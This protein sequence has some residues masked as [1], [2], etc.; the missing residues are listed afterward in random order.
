M[1]PS[2]VVSYQNTLNTSNAPLL[3]SGPDRVSD[4][5]FTNYFWFGPAA[6]NTVVATATSIGRSPFDMYSGADIWPGRNPQQRF[7]ST[8]WL[9]NYFTGNNPASPRTSLAVFAPNL[10]FN[11]GLNSFNSNPADYQNFYNTE[12]RLFAGDDPDITTADARGWPGFG[13]YQPV[14]CALTVAEIGA[15]ACGVPATST[16]LAAYW[17]CNDSPSLP[18]ADASGHGHPGAL[19]NMAAS[20][21]SMDAPAQ[22]ATVTATRPASASAGLHRQHCLR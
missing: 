2:G 3:Q 4:A 19:S 7:N 11:G 8:A 12:V 6:I 9:G 14:R 17:Q 18:A 5:I 21:W 16:A 10:T 1:L 20:D 13:Y 22:C 15:N